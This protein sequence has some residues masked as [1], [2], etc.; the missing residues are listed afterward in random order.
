VP[1]ANFGTQGFSAGS[2]TTIDTAIRL[3][4]LRNALA[5]EGV[6]GHQQINFE[7]LLVLDPDAIVLSQPLATEEAHTGDRGGAAERI[8]LGESSLAELR[9]VRSRAFLRLDAGLYASASH[10]I[11]RA[12]EELQRQAVA[13]A[14]ALEEPP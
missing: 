4:G 9:A 3:A 11:V 6:T 2:G 8:L 1:Y 10:G 13:L 12:A 5:E 14:A 7:A